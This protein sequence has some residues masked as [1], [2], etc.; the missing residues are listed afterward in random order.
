MKSIAGL[1]LGAATTMFAVQSTMAQ[2]DAQSA[3]IEE[4]VVTAQKRSEN[5]QSVPISIVAV[6]SSVLEDNGVASLD[7]LQRLAPGMNMSTVGSGFVS[8][9]YIRGGGTNVIDAG[10]D[11][12]VAVFV[13]EVYQAGTTGLQ[14][15]LLDIDR[16]E[17]LKGPQGTLFGRNAAVGAISIITKRPSDEFGTS[18]DLNLGNHGEKS[19][20]GMLT[21][22]LSSDGAWRYRVAAGYR[23]RDAFTDNPAGMDPGFIDN[24]S[25]RAQLERVSDTF[26]FRLTGDYFSSDNGMTNQYLATSVVTGFIRPEAAATLPA[27]Q[28]RFRR[29]YSF[30]DGYERQDAGSATA[31]MEWETGIG[32]ITSISAY[33]DLNFRRIQ[34][35]DGSAAAGHELITHEEV[36]SWSQELRLAGEA[37]RWRWVGGLYYYDAETNRLDIQAAGADFPTAAA[38][39]TA[40][41]YNQNI[42]TRS[43][44]VFG[45][46]T[47]DLSDRWALTLGGRYSKDRKKSFQVIDPLGPAGVF[48][49]SLSPE[50]D[51]FDPSVVLE[52]EPS[53]DLMFY[54]SYRQGY[55]SG[56]FQTLP[57][58]VVLANSPFA[59]EHV[60]SYE[61]GM[62]S[63]WSDNRVRFNTALFYVDIDDQQIQRI[64][65]AGI[66]QIDN[67]GRTETRGVDLGLVLAP[68][69][70]LRF[71]V[72]ATFQRARFKEYITGVVSFAGNHQLRSP[73][74]AFAVGAEYEVPVS[75]GDVT[76]RA[77]YS[78][79]SRMYFDAAN[80]SQPNN[81]QPGYGLLNARVIL[82]M[83]EG[84]ELALW[85][86]NLADEEYFR[87]IAVVTGAGL[88]VPGDP[89]TYGISVSWKVN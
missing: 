1:V 43:H 10:S 8:Y 76:L 17:V 72:N 32:T 46:A 41:S 37:G 84:W 5:V 48:T 35:Q 28:A 26:Q 7:G 65:A 36:R 58:S 38:R 74:Q 24:Y 6:D 54:G 52:F 67:A 44:A 21:G 60:R 49:A 86:V 87:N 53:D 64:P 33:R 19:L 78:Y 75:F 47:V 69:D 71:D 29:Y 56:G 73:D 20:R 63:E 22:P 51:S 89:R 59:P 79:Q 83:G 39:G 68:T 40:G 25:A 23:E 27:D 55:K 45:Q 30:N 31:R 70:A 3:G 4:V 81:F 15:T 82:G 16:I 14:S 18:L 77:D 11:P 2:T 61:L 34:D 62:K 88:A 12:S 50:W 80:S 57:S 85:G 9:T 66:A 42:D 13:D